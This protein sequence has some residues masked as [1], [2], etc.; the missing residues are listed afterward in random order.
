M[1]R[2]AVGVFVNNEIRLPCTPA[3][4]NERDILYPM[5]EEMGC[6]GFFVCFF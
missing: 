1:V 5:W 2:L 6:V 3:G 4:C